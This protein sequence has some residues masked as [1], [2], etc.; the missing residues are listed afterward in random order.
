MKKTESERPSLAQLDRELARMRY[1]RRFRQLMRSTIGTLLVV[2]A[3]ASIAASY[4]FSLIRVDGVSMTPAFYPGDLLLAQRT[5]QFETGDIIAFYFDN[6]LLLKRVIGSPGDWVELQADGTVLV[7]GEV[8]DEPYVTE[9]SFGD[10]DV[11]YPCQIP[12]NHWFVLGDHRVT[13]LDSRYT[14]I[15]NIAAEQVYGKVLFRLWPL[16][17]SSQQTEEL[18]SDASGGV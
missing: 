10:G 5:A 6:K 13:S 7:N 4:F 18:P 17:S 8:L 11:S 3:I 2:A 1:W 14:T 16:H 15:G 12:E 9:P